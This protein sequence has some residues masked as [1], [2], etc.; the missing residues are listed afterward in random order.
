MFEGRILVP[1]PACFPQSVMEGL[2]EFA[3]KTRHLGCYSRTR[4]GSPRAFKSNVI[5]ADAA[6]K[7]RFRSFQQNI[8]KKGLQRLNGRFGHGFLNNSSAAERWLWARCMCV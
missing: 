2:F 6:I 5:R 7:G 4:G 1:A 3:S 8:A